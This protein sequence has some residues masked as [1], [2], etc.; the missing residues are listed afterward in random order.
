VNLVQTDNAPLGGRL[1]DSTLVRVRALGANAVALLPFLYAPDSLGDEI[2][3]GSAVS[4]TQ[5][6]EGIRAVHRQGLKVVLKPHVWVTGTWAGAIAPPVG[7]PRDRWFERYTELIVHYAAIAQR[8]RVWMFSVGTELD[9]LIADSTHWHDL[10]KRVR[11]V[12]RGRVTYVAHDASSLAIIT[13]RRLLDESAVSL[14]PSLGEDQDE[15]AI[16]SRMRATLDTVK[17][18]ARTDG[19]KVLVAEVGLRSAQGAIRA[20]WE[21]AEERAAPPDEGLQARVISYWLDLLAGPWCS[22]VLIWR[23]FTDPRAGGPYDTDFTIQG[24]AAE[25]LVR[26]RWNIK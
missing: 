19:R 4:D 24:K 22:G 11:S 10:I 15:E 26:G 1:A 23:W 16:R 8:E 17:H 9:A 2:H 25:F 5:I 12:Y 20:P 21:S 3:F 18:I 13:W 14:Y 7:Q 6:V